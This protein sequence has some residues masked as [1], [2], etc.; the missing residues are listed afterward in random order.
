MEIMIGRSKTKVLLDEEDYVRFFVKG[1]F[2]S[3]ASHG[4]VRC[5]KYVGLYE[6]TGFGKYSN[7]YLHRMV[8]RAPKNLMVDHINGNR[9]DNRKE[10]LRLCSVKNNA[11]NKK[12]KNGY[13]GIYFDKNI[14]KWVA[15][16]TKNYHTKSL[17]CF[18]SPEEAALAYNKAAKKIHGKYAFLNIIKNNV[19]I[20]I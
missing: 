17:G 7:H 4:Y 15:Q 20:N 19:K 1:N 11:V 6:T 2:F 13:K 9:L 16:I 5:M 3:I 8:M 12:G 10:N 14:Q 18:K